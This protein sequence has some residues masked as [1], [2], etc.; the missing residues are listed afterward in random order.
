MPATFVGGDLFAYAGLD[1]LAHGCNCAGAM[2]KGIA[3]EFKR[4][5]PKMYAEY[6]ALCASGQFRLGGVFVWRGSE[7][8]VFN[9]GTQR[10]WRSPADSSA[11]ESALR[12]MCQLAERMGLSRVGLPRI[13]SGLGGLPW[14]DVRTII[15]RVSALTTIELVVFED[16]HGA[17]GS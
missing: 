15:E 1:A 5:F 12:E 17:E 13:G 3:L 2:G 8:I 7:A 4:R 16:F 9:L 10:S 14:S 11:I 6:K